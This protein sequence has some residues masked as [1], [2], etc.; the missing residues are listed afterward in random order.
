MMRIRQSVTLRH[1]NSQELS[2]QWTMAPGQMLVPALHGVDAVC[3]YFIV[4]GLV[5]VPVSF[6]FL[7]QFYGSTC[8]CFLSNVVTANK[9]AYTQ[10]NMGIHSANNT[11]N[12]VCV[13]SPSLAEYTFG[14]Q[15][16]GAGRP[17]VTSSPTCSSTAAPP[18]SSW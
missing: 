4:G 12:T 14:T 10:N 6:P 9:C 3:S 17:P 13:Y 7:E 15:A 16:S 5:F 11:S 18:T 2:V 8:G 1:R